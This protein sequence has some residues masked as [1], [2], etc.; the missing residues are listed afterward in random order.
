MWHREQAAGQLEPGGDSI[1]SPDGQCYPEPLAPGGVRREKD[2][3]SIKMS[4][5]F[6]DPSETADV[7]SVWLSGL[8]QWMEKHN[9][10][11]INVE[12]AK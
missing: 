4:H 2:F 7:C 3:N 9:A 10:A 8:E 5:P 6:P 11:H 12:R 1:L